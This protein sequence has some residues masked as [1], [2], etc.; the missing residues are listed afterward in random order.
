M[1][2]QIKLLFGLVVVGTMVPQHR[3]HAQG[4]VRKLAPGVV[5]VIPS[6]P[7]TEET[8]QGPVALPNI[9]TLDWDPF[10]SPKTATL[11]QKSSGIV[12]RHNVWNLEFAFKPV[13]MIY[14][15]IPQPTGR[16]HR[17][18]VWYMVY[19][20]KNKGD[21]MM[22]NPVKDQ[23]EHITY[24]APVKVDEVLNFGAAQPSGTI[25]FFP[26]F[27]LE[28]HEQGKAYLDRVIPV[29]IPPI[30]LREMRG[31]KLYNTVEITRVPI[32]V[33][34]EVEDRSV[35]GVV[36]WEDIDPRI[37]YFSIYVQ[38]LTN[39]FRL[40]RGQYLQKTLKLNFWRPGDV[41]YEHEKEIRYGVPAVSDAAE[42]ANILAKY[43]LKE[44]VDH[45][46]LYR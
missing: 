43:G 31:G 44:R 29:A 28:S 7:K 13:R 38:G 21:H 35:W 37:D 16:M 11:R 30:Q 4:K 24:D 23:F 17:K 15:D 9:T 42:Q 33:S 19:R 2:W 8:Y 18:L 34:T 10:F 45:L 22:P 1:T 3:T 41:V 25:R 27:V 32:P 14:V 39:A 36:T 46:W 12:L 6:E 40:E 5:T 26:H 20:V